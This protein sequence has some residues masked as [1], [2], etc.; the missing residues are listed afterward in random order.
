MM[1]KLHRLRRACRRLLP[2]RRRFK[3]SS[4]AVSSVL[5]IPECVPRRTAFVVRKG[6][7]G[8]WLVFDCPCRARH[9]VVLNLDPQNGPVWRVVNE[10]PLTL[11]PSVDEYTSRGRCHYLISKGKVIWI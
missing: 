1:C 7:R 10:R 3:T 5:D 2:F 9:R 6:Q 4:E 8:Q 11:Y